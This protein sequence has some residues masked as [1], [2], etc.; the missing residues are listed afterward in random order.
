MYIL[1][2]IMQKKEIHWS[3]ANYI[4]IQGDLNNLFKV[5][6]SPYQ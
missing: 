6:H 2:M 1:K 4:G 5:I 3:K